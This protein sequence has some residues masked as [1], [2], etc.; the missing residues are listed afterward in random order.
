MNHL[1]IARYEKLLGEL[2]L[3]PKDE[4]IMGTFL[5]VFRENDFVGTNQYTPCEVSPSTKNKK[6]EEVQSRD[7][8]D[9]FRKK[10][11]RCDTVGTD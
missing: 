5:S 10:N 11:K 2:Y 9:M 1:L 8:R 7:I 6:N 4:E 3:D